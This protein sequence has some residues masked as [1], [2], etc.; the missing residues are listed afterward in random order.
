VKITLDRHEETQNHAINLNMMMGEDFRSQALNNYHKIVELEQQV[1][2]YQAE[3]ILQKKRYL[4]LHTK[5]RR[6]TEQHFMDLQG[7]YTT[8]RKLE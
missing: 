7:E 3:P 8:Q 1:L 6:F 5:F 2:L 4:K